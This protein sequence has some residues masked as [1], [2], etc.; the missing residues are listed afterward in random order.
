MP[1]T[2]NLRPASAARRPAAMHSAASPRSHRPPASCT[3]STAFTI[4]APAFSA[5][6]LAWKSRSSSPFSNM[7]TVPSSWR[8]RRCQKTSPLASAIATPRS[9][10]ARAA[11]SDR[12]RS[13]RPITSRASQ[14]TS[15]CPVLSAA[16]R[17]A[18]AA[19]T[20]SSVRPVPT[21]TWAHSAACW[22][23]RAAIPSATGRASSSCSSASCHRSPATAA[24]AISSCRRTRRPGSYARAASQA[25]AIAA[26]SS[27]RPAAASTSASTSSAS[28]APSAVADSS[29]A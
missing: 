19:R 13:T 12:R 3:S 14:A 16:W 29:T 20:A 28:A 27:T 5:S 1:S 26:A 22:A 9:N 10:A 23:A 6:D 11:G 8:A 15:G 18:F 25:R 4:S 21:A 17:A 2:R 7:S 24:L